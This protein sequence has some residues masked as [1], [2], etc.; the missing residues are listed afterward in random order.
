M[1]TVLT[2]QQRVEA[3]LA[4]AGVAIEI[5]TFPVGTRTA[6]DAAAAIGCSVAEIAKSIV[7]RA[8]ESDRVVVVVTSGSNRVDERKVAGLLGQAVVRADADFVRSKTGFAIGGVAPVGHL[9]APLVLMDRDLQQYGQVWA[10]GGTGDS[11]FRI[12][13]SEL[14]TLTQ[15]PLADIKQE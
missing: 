1:S 10:A 8:V 5:K 15:A 2:S 12:T 11:V 9:E 3:A 7:L 13:P 6:A 14:Q 4:A